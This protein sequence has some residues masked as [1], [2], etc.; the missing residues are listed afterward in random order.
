MLKECVQD[1]IAK[2]RWM[3]GGTH[4][5]ESAGGAENGVKK[6][7]DVGVQDAGRGR[8]GDGPGRDGARVVTEAGRWLPGRRQTG[9]RRRAA[10]SGTRRARERAQFTEAVRNMPTPRL[11]PW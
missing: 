6:A 2:T 4:R 3:V 1:E 9:P 5:R 11:W 8:V 7:G 10:L